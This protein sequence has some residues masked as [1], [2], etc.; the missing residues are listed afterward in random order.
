MVNTKHMEKMECYAC[1]STWMP[2]YYGYKYVIDYTKSSTDWL[3]SPQLYGKDGTTADYHQ[4]FATQPG[5]PTYGDYSHIRWENAPLGVN[6]EGRVS[7]LVGVI[8]TVSTVIDKDGKTVVWNNVAKTQEGYNAIELAPLN[9]HTTSLKSREC[10]DC[11]GNPVAAG[12]GID[13][14]IY[15]AKPGTPRYADVVDA[16]GNNVSKYTQA[17]IAAISELHGDFMQLLT[18]DGKQVQTIDTHWPTSVPLTQ[19]QRDLLTRKNACI[20]CHQ[21]IPKGTIPN[22]ML[23]KIAEIAKLSFATPEEHTSLLHSN[24]LMIAW[25]K[26]LGVVGLIVM[27]GIIV[28]AVIKR[29]QLASFWKKFVK[30]FK[31][32]AEE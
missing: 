6:G 29:K 8:Q 25:I 9:P 10:V 22:R 32:S 24:N 11:H 12:Y 18:L 28:L 21:D 5:A 7:P 31:N 1:H 3:R 26:A 15:D 4:K 23:T 2:Q 13:G 27:A 16:E 30:S 17:Q 14:G 20:A 19:S